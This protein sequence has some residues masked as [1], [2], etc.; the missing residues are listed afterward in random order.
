MLLFTNIVILQS[1]WS[2]IKTTTNLVSPHFFKLYENCYNTLDY[3]FFF[4]V[5]ETSLGDDIWPKL[6]AYVI[7]GRQQVN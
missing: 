7:S 5:Q 3:D 4:L 6:E 1:D 2:I